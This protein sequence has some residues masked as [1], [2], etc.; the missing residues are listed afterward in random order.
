METTTTTT[1]TASIPMTKTL[2]AR[3]PAKKSII[4]NFVLDSALLLVFLVIY[5]E[6]ATGLTIHEWGGLALAIVAMVH[7]LLHWKWIISCGK[8]FLRNVKTEIRLNY[9]IN[10]LLFVAFTAVIFSGIMMSEVVMPLFGIPRVN[11]RF[12]HWLHAL[13]ADITLGLVVL[14]IAMHGKWIITTAKRMIFGARAP[15]PTQQP[16]STS[17]VTDA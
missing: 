17:T 13:S 11:S 8:C 6:H 7:I 3:R 1:S 4:T 5:E 14:H 2:T 9:L 15:K 16:K 10:M 12:W